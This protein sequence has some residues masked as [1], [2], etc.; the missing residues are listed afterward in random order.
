MRAV[1]VGGF[2]NGRQCAER[3][4]LALRKH[5]SD[6]TPYTFSYAMSHRD[7]VREAL[8]GADAITHSAGLLAVIGTAPNRITAFGAPI[9]T[10]VRQFIGRTATKTLNMH[11]PGIGVQ[12]SDDIATVRLYE[13]SSCA[14]L[15]INPLDNF[16]R[17][18]KISRFDAV[19]AAITATQN[20]TPISLIYTHGDEFFQPTEEH[21]LIAQSAGVG[22]V[23]L[24]GAH[25]ELV[26][27]PEA[28]LTAA[29]FGS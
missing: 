27:R 8:C 6:V 9:P 28:M 4:A 10:P 21:A 11:K 29:G 7:E 13:S 14:E 25:D 24:P 16:G 20:G 12:S 22:F 15:L 26:L 17:L 2:G 19:A 1:Y 3:V 18:G 23:R 5:Y